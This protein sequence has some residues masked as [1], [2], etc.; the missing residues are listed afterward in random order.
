MLLI[1]A[2]RSEME[3]VRR[4]CHITANPIFDIFAK[5]TAHLRIEPDYVIFA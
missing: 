3:H 4:I 5:T 2:F 1:G